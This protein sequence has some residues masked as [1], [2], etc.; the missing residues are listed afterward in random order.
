MDN[1]GQQ[2]YGAVDAQAVDRA[3]EGEDVTVAG[4]QTVSDDGLELGV[5][6][7]TD[8]IN[9]V[10]APQGLDEDGLDGLND[11]NDSELSDATE[12]DD[13]QQAPFTRKPGRGCEHYSRGCRLVSPCCGVQFWCRFCH[14]AAM[15][16][17]NSRTG[18]TLDRHAV[19]AVLRK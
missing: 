6:T 18:H 19:K 1:A 14:N 4:A 9:G 3:I 11:G 5:A 7:E 8:A 2:V 12:V 10:H 15:D 13:T 16:T 17:G